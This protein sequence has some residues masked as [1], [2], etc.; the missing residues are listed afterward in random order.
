MREIDERKNVVDDLGARLSADLVGRGKELEV[1]AH[2][3]VVV[4][5]EEIRHVS[6]RAPDVLGPGVDGITRHARDSGGRPQ[7]RREDLDGRRLARAVR[8][9]ETED[10]APVDLQIQV[11]ERD[12]VAITLGETYGLDHFVSPPGD[13]RIPIGR[14]Q[15]VSPAPAAGSPSTSI[16]R[17][18]ERATAN[19][20]G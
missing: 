14:R 3:E 11:G 9:D 7:E 1:L 18:E 16:G 4:E 13:P 17:A 19:T 10:V 12:P 2:R 8:T 6:H 20:I 15:I 5:T